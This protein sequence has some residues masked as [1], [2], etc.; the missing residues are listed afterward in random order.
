MNKTLGKKL[1]LITG[2]SAILLVLGVFSITVYYG[3]KGDQP[4]LAVLK[5]V[6]FEVNFHMPFFLLNSIIVA[7]VCFD[8]QSRKLAINYHILFVILSLVML[9]VNL[10]L[11]LK[12]IM[13]L[14]SALFWLLFLIFQLQKRKPSKQMN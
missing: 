3:L 4:I 6:L 7:I 11:I 1:I 10:A 12:N 5:L 2:I 9:V 14:N 8:L 13:A